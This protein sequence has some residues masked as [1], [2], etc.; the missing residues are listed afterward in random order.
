MS[1]ENR[2]KLPIISNIYRTLRCNGCKTE[3]KNNQRVWR[4]SFVAPTYVLVCDA[5]VDTLSTIFDFDPNGSKELAQVNW[6]WQWI[7]TIIL[8]RDNN[9]CRM[10]HKESEMVKNNWENLGVDVHHIIPRKDGGTNNFKNLITLCKPCHEATFKNGFAGIPKL[11]DEEQ[12]TLDKH[13]T[14][15]RVYPVISKGER[16]I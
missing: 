8:R 3:F 15:F 6:S 5:C 16:L 11:F 9:R 14:E 4:F 13:E 7:R 2:F 12:L 10:N 1:E